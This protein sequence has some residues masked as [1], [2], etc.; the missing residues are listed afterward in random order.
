MSRHHGPDAN[1]LGRIAEEVMREMKF[2]TQPPADAIAQAAHV[3]DS[4][5]ADG[6]KDMSDLPWTS[7]DNPESR[8]LDQIEV[9]ESIAEGIRLYVG[10]ADVDAFVPEGS[11]IDRFAS[12]NTT[13]VYTGV[14]TFPML[15]DRLSF[16][17]TSLLAERPRLA[18]VFETVIGKDGSIGAHKSYRALVRNH[19]KL[20]YPAV[21]AWLDGGPIAKGLENRPDLQSQVRQQDEL[22]HVLREARRR[23]G[24]LDVETD[25]TRPVMQDGE[26]T[27]L[28]AQKQDRAGR[29]IEELMIASNR[30]VANELDRANVPSIRR[31]VKQPERWTK[32]A[33]YAAERGVK[34]PAT[35]SSLALS[36]FVDKMRAERPA[37]FAE[38]S[39]A[40]VK[41][42]GRGEYVAHAP[43][44]QEIGHFGLA[45][46]EYT[47]STAPNRRYADLV[48]QRIVKNC[49]RGAA[50]SLAQLNE[51]ATHGSER[52]AAAEKV[53]RRVHKS[54][55]ASLLKSR[56][57]EKFQGIITGAADKG[58]FVRLFHPH[59]EGKIVKG[60]QGLRVGDKVTVTLQDTDVQRGFIDFVI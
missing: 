58:T 13:S 11:P 10:I 24:A 30:A 3:P 7:I 39:L 21:S 22:A 50:Y 52:E 16:D 53:E 17:A 8:D 25:Q 12:A 29:I 45:T 42:M 32:I 54:A 35:P 43:G 26:V 47:H 28:V 14:R 48:T 36:Q 33:L 27:A 5:H 31:V 38:I 6:V 40:I 55:A 51:I 41:L 59:A 20:D 9:T 4:P 15:P 60:Q 57:G 37:E 19:A 2:I 18:V 44:T 49:A 56:I 34:L 46:S 1:M 23:L